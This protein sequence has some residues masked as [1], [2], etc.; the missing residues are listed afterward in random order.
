[1]NIFFNNY[2]RFYTLSTMARKHLFD[3]QKA[4]KKHP[5]QSKATAKA[6]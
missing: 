6:Q 3:V 2:C 5:T 4:E 1:M